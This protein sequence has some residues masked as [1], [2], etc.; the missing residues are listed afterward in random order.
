MTALPGASQPRLSTTPTVLVASV[1]DPPPVTSVNCMIDT[2]A[3]AGVG[4]TLPQNTD[5]WSFPIADPP[6]Y[7]LEGAMQ[8]R[9]S[10]LGPVACNI[11][12]FAGDAD[13]AV[14][15]IPAG[16][17]FDYLPSGSSNSWACVRVW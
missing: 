14:K 6:G 3:G 16:Q 12:A 11:L 2:S 4:I 13:P 9:L 17:C 10:N 5:A 1:A 8:I 15:V 7:G